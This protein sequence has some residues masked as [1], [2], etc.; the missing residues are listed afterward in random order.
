MNTNR[1]K[2][3]WTPTY[4]MN[5][6]SLFKK[7]SQPSAPQAPD[8]TK[9]P[10]ATASLA[11]QPAIPMQPSAFG[12]SAFG[13]QAAAREP[14]AGH[15]ERLAQVHE[16]PVEAEALPGEEH[17]RRRAYDEGQEHGA[18][19][20][21]RDRPPPVRREDIGA[22]EQGYGEDKVAPAQKALQEAAE[23][24]YE[25]RLDAEPAYEREY[26]EEAAD[27]GP[28]LAP[29]GARGLLLRALP[30]AAGRIFLCRPGG[31]LS[32]SGGISHFQR[33]PSQL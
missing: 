14:R 20:A 30:G 8:F 15:V 5:K 3:A 33:L 26:A 10:D 9:A 19:H 4:G 27:D 32:P 17:M 22:R 29:Y 1:T 2:Y 7:A 6:K 16:V 18:A 23:H 25:E 24:V 31:L 12:Q 13:Q 28:H 11:S 21:Q